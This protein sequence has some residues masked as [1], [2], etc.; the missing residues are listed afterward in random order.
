ME[1]KVVLV[2]GS[3]SGIGKEIA[4]AFAEKGAIVAIADLNLEAAKATAHEI[5][6]H[7]KGKAI[8]IRMD[9]TAEAEVE[10]GVQELLQKFG[11][12]DILVSN[13]GIQ[14]I[15]PIDQLELNQWKKCSR[16]I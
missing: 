1:N 5:Q 14:H 8:A 4:K 15:A 16:F 12:L 13:A 3:A 2:T 11:K 7:T 10:N 9:V 6:S